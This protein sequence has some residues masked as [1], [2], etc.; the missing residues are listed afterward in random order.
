MSWLRD[1]QEVDGQRTC[2]FFV[3]KNE[4]CPGGR[5]QDTLVSFQ[6]IGAGQRL[7]LEATH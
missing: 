3:S 2:P 4:K 7:M 6:A 5:H 1:P